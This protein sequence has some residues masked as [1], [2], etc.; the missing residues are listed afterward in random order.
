MVLDPR[1]VQPHIG[2]TA[3]RGYS[4]IINSTSGV[5]LNAAAFTVT[6]TAAA[7]ALATTNYMTEQA[8]LQV[9][10]ATTASAQAGLSTTTAFAVYSTTA[11]RGGF[12][13]VVRFGAAQ[14]PTGPRLFA[15]LTS[16]TMVGSSEPSA[17]VASVAAFGK[18]ST[19]TNIQLLVNSNSGGGTKTDTGIALVATGWYEATVWAEP[20]GGTI[21]GLLIRLDTG[22]IW[23]GSTTT[24]IPANGALLFPQLLG[25][26]NATNTGTA[27]QLTTGTLL[28]RTGT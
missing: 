17:V 25:G 7:A 1:E 21:Y 9:N 19:D 13:F 28:V 5:V 18:D 27:F 24:D 12:E 11:G 6:G 4:V 2:G 23:F 14:L 16:S 8:R 10:S 20:G 3:W 22:A 26:L 15:G